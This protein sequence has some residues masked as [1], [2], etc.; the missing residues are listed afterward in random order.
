LPA[1]REESLEHNQSVTVLGQGLRKY[2]RPQGAFP[3]LP[4]MDD[5]LRDFVVE[6]SEHL[7]TVDAELVKFERD[8]NNGATLALI[9]RPFTRSKAHA[10]FSACRV[11]SVSPTRRRT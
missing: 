3:D 7:E 4:A 6:T 10:V 5:L 9:F 8:P 11:W 1:R 2:Q